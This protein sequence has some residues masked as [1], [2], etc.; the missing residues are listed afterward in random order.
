MDEGED[1][2][3]IARSPRAKAERNFT[4]GNSV[5]QEQAEEDYEAARKRIHCKIQKLFS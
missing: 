3:L 5:V 2:T 4:Y 1:L